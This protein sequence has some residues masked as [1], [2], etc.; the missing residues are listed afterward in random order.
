MII[1]REIQNDIEKRLFRKKVVIIY[2]ARRVG[3]TTLIREIQKKFQDISLYLNCDEPDIREAL[4]DKTSTELKSFIGPKQL[5][6]IDEA[7]RVRNIGLTLKLIVDNY[8]E[9][10]I[11]S[12][13]SSSFELSNQTVEP[14]TGRKY[15]YF[16]YPFSISELKSIYSNIEI[17]RLLEKR[18][19]F[20][21][22]PEI[23]INEFE[24]ERNLKE[25]TRS[26]LY[27]DV[28]QYQ[29]IRNPEILEKLLQ[30]LA[31]QLGNEVSY[32][33]LSNSL[34]IDKK[35]VQSY[36]SILE[37]AFVI[38]KLGPFSK[39]LRNEIKKLRKIYF[40]DTGIRNALINNLNPFTLRN[41]MG[42]LWENF[43]IMERMKNTSNNFLSK[44]IYFW[45]THQKEEIDLIEESTD[46]ICAYEFKW[47]NKKT[48]KEKAP[49]AFSDKYKN[50]SFKIVDRK[51]YQ[52][53]LKI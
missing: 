42:V 50:I 12:T 13:G 34:G 29:H 32:N 26:Y 43:L 4:T 48:V 24:N 7:Q 33:E 19:I 20:G 9:I 46:N 41:D 38:F 47:K 36:I 1:K 51:N 6:I 37:K 25:I 53:F 14:L 5:V 11:I 15:E 16:L 31:L 49:K 22:Y 30:A 18:I 17:D 28:L 52:E 10:Q 23:V 3:K 35:T 8:P 21:M 39:N 45:R 2:G 44:N 27:K 40:I